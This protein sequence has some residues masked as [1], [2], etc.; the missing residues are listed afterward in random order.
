[1]KTQAEITFAQPNK[2]KPK[3][4]MQELGKPANREGWFETCV[5]EIDDARL[6][7]RPP[8]LNDYGFQLVQSQTS[9]TEMPQEEDIQAQGFSEVNAAILLATGAAQVIIFDHTIRT[10]APDKCVR[11]TASHAHN[12]Y[13]PKSFLQKL[14]DLGIEPAGRRI[15]EL[16]AWRP[17][18][19]PVKVAPLA[20]ADGRTVKN[21]Q[22]IECALVYPDR[23]GEIYELAYAASQRWFYFPEMVRDELLLFK[24][25]DSAENA[26]AKL[27]PHSAFRHPNEEA[28]WPARLSIEFRTIVIY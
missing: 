2:D 9:L 17:L 27:C 12:D 24:G 20:L 26:A 5:V 22:L 8:T 15:Q 1:M 21:N 19:E 14:S 6:L 3:Y 18:R 28:T 16:N 4:I 23:E 25:F 10:S 13:T 7:Q 11:G